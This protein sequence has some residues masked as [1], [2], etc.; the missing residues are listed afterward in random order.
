MVTAT[1]RPVAGSP[2]GTGEVPYCATAI[3]AFAK[4]LADATIRQHQH[5]S[6]LSDLF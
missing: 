1:P 2:R 5:L 3:E 6:N 4:R